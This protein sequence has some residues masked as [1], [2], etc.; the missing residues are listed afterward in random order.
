MSK[1]ELITKQQ[2]EI[3]DLK[4]TIADYKSACNDARCYLFRPEQWSTKC[5]D[6]PKVAM[7]GIVQALRAIEDI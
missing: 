3:E 1:D 5:P 7:T 4:S 2:L 6:F